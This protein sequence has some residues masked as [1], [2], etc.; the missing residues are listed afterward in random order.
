MMKP[1]HEITAGFIGSGAMGSA[2]IKAA[3]RVIDKKRIFITS[4]AAEKRARVASE[5]GVMEAGDNTGLTTLG[6][7]VFLAVKPPQLP[8]VLREIAPY[9]DGKI[10]VS[11]AAGI[12]LSSIRA[13]L[14]GA[15]PLALIRAMPNIA[16]SVG[17]SMTALAVE[18]SFSEA[19]K[20]LE[21]VSLTRELLSRGGL[22]ELVDE[23][24]MD[25][26]TAI[27]G[28][29]PAYAFIFIEA[30]G[31][32]AVSLG[33]PRS[34]AYTFAAQTLKGAAVLTLES[35]RH[36]AELKDAVCSPSGSTIE[37]VCALEAGGFRSSII[38]AARNAAKKA[39][40]LAGEDKA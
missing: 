8:G 1:L 34:R 23:G 25:C 28:S 15:S 20:T 16:A 17:E 19:E 4:R 11:A 37:A 31:D 10:L 33:M 30:L 29:G 22:V 26:V 18:K 24:L 2:L 13:S 39:R 9:C 27:S 35:G 14:G 36:P 32:A 21:A 3:S 12:T 5:L 40:S 7:I 38:E 6:D